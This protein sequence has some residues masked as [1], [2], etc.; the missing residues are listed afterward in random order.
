MERVQPIFRLAHIVYNE[1]RVLKLPVVLVQL[2]QSVNIESKSHVHAEIKTD[3]GRV[4]QLLA[5]IFNCLGQFLHLN[6]AANK[7]RQCLSDDELLS[8]N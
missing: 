5:L 2:S 4:H 7:L 8:I 6:F 3:F 1:D